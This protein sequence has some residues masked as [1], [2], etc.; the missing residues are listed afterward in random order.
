MFF[1]MGESKE[2]H[3]LNKKLKLKLNSDLTLSVCVCVCVCVCAC[4]C[5]CGGGGGCQTYFYVANGVDKS[6]ATLQVNMCSNLCV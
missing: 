6:E 3:S 1:P 5:V 4:V 2:Q